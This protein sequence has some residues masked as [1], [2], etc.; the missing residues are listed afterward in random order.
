MSHL[1]ECKYKKNYFS[2][3]LIFIVVPDDLVDRL[4][5]YYETF[6]SKPCCFT[7]IRQYTTLLDDQQRRK[8]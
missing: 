8:V 1:I 2:Q 5:G 6:G 7:D 3:L 4:I